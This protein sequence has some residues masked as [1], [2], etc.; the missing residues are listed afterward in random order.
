MKGSEVWSVAK[1]L[2]PDLGGELTPEPQTI[3]S[4]KASVIELAG[5]FEAAGWGPEA[6]GQ[7]VEA[8]KAAEWLTGLDATELA[9]SMATVVNAYGS[10]YSGPYP[11]LAVDPT[12]AAWR[13]QT[14]I[15]NGAI[16]ET[17]GHLTIRNLAPIAAHREVPFEVLTEWVVALTRRGVRNVIRRI[18]SALRWR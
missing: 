8:A 1:H 16:G 5:I 11:L 10:P 12:D 4:R 9:H 3:S 18:R 2:R 6:V 15:R 7:G 14:M 13:I 17:D